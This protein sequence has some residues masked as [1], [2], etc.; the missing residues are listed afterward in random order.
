MIGRMMALAPILALSVALAA[1]AA[2]A[3]TV[4]VDGGQLYY[5]TCGSG[6]QAIVLIHD[7]VINSASFDEVWTRATLRESESNNRRFADR[8]WE[9]SSSSGPPSTSP[10]STKPRMAARS[11]SSFGVSDSVTL[12]FI[13]R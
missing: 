11:D 6:R 10:A 12:F 1:G 13:G 4:D 8:W 9:L 2:R 3:E 7:G 5:E